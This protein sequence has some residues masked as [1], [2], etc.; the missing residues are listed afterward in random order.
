MTSPP[1]GQ[2][3]YPG[4][5]HSAEFW[6]H[7]LYRDCKVYLYFDHSLL[8]QFDIPPALKYAYEV[9]AIGVVI[10]RTKADLKTPRIRQ[11]EYHICE[12]KPYRPQFNSDVTP[13]LKYEELSVHTSRKL[14][15]NVQI[16]K[17][18]GELYV[19]KFMTNDSSQHEFEGEVQRYQ[20]LKSSPGVP[21]FKGVV[22][23]GGILQGF[24]ISYIDG[25]DLWTIVT[26]NTMIGEGVLLDFTRRIIEVAVKLEERGFYHQ[27]LKCPNIIRRQCD[28]EIFFID[29]GPGTTEH[30]YRQERGAVIRRNGAD[31]TDGMYI[32]GK[33]L[34]Q[35]W[36]SD[37][38]TEEDRLERIACVSVRQIIADCLMARFETMSKLYN[39]YYSNI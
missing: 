35:L 26:Q 23:A 30:M 4:D 34:W 9:N 18:E 36:C 32:L 39:E 29:L 12:F 28:G 14:A 16:V 21:E 17:F 5:K 33:T 6:Y 10:T 8:S 2:Y 7:C 38:P 1:L 19:H 20:L 31:V 22:Q 24:L 3:N 37:S 27:D 11:H 25:E 15:L 13:V